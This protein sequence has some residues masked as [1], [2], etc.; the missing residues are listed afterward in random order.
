MPVS[1]NQLRNVLQSAADKLTQREKAQHLVNA[2]CEVLSVPVSSLYVVTGDELLLVATKGL[3]SDGIGSTRLPLGVGLVGS[4]AQSGN[5][6]NLA[7]APGHPDF[8]R[9]DT[10][11]EDSFVGFLGVPIVHL[12]H[13]VGVLVVQTNESRAFNDDEESFVITIASQ[14]AIDFD[15]SDFVQTESLHNYILNG[16]AAS[17]GIGIGSVVW[18]DSSALYEDIDDAPIYQPAE[19]RGCFEGALQRAKQDVDDT[20]GSLGVE[21]DLDSLAEAYRAMLSDPSFIE[22]VYVFIEQ[23][24]CASFAVQQ[25]SESI[26]EAL[27]AIDDPYLKARADDVFHV[28][29]KIVGHCRALDL[30]ADVPDGPVVLVGH[31]VAAT[32]IAAYSAGGLAGVISS[33]GSGL[34]H[35][36][37][38]AK[39]LGIPCVM[40]VENISAIDAGV[41]IV[42]EGNLGRV[43]VHP[44][45]ALLQEYQALRDR[46]LQEYAELAELRDLM[47]ITLDGQRIQL[48]VNTGLL[49]EITPG[50]K[51]GAEG[52][53]LYRSEIPFL[54]ADSFPTESEQEAIYRQVLECYNGKPVYMRTLDIGGDKPLPYFSFSEE[55]PFLGWRGIRF[56]LDNR[57]ILRTQLRAMLRAS[58]GLPT[59]NIMVPMVGEIDQIDAFKAL[60]EQCRQELLEA[61]H[62]VRQPRVG[63]MLEVPSLISQMD[64][65]SDRVDFISIGSNDLTQY[66]LAVDRNNERVASLFNHVHP[67]VIHEVYRIVRKSKSLGI[68]IGVCGEMASHPLAVILLLGMDVDS[69]SMSAF[70]LPKIKCLIRALSQERAEMILQRALRKSSAAAIHEL[71]LQ[72]L[73]DSGV[74]YLFKSL[75]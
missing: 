41:A 55:N 53:G 54:V 10:L 2:I 47:A 13:T 57:P 43:I 59:L 45:S 58:I 20:L 17:P 23:G 67:A 69:L 16:K 27:Q 66:L 7:N 40:G 73:R 28:A 26:I 49:S 37:I 44:T 62:N 12:G 35:T 52:I 56:A 71:L 11:A 21:H 60:L 8:H 15:I 51:M 24:H 48:L 31:N 29:S 70:Q 1:I 34:S 3:N 14:L 72:E 64:F 33:S 42:V 63:I 61:G 18:L 74:D 25:A 6:L 19:Q 50:L 65:L 38:V 9:V 4:I 68:K 39:A 46:E 32:D 75:G 5:A 30:E 22:S 36:A